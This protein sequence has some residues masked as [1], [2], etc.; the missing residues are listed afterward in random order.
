VEGVGGVRHLLD[1]VCAF[2]ALSVLSAMTASVLS[3]LAVA[4]PGGW[5][6]WRFWLAGFAVLELGAVLGAVAFVLEEADL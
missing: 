3:L 4:D 1:F 6:A 2:F 5:A